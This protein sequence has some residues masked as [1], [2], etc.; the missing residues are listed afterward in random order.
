MYL[1]FA[2][3][4]FFFLLKK[5]ALVLQIN[6]LHLT[7]FILYFV[8]VLLFKKGELGRKRLEEKLRKCVITHKLITKSFQ[9][10]DWNQRPEKTYPGPRGPKG[11]GSVSA[12]LVRYY[13]KSNV[14]PIV[15]NANC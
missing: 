6:S 8:V 2:Y 5:C 7:R 10:M 11:S 1:V 15:L 9:N 14:K 4:M 12:L 3:G 13:K